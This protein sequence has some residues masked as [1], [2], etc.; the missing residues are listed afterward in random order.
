MLNEILA[1]VAGALRAA[2]G[3]GFDIYRN[4]VRQGLHEPCFFLAVLQPERT[5]LLGRRFRWTVPLDVHYFPERPGRNDELLDVA[6]RAAEA[7][8][9]ITLPDGAT[10]RGFS[11][12]CETE[13]GVLHVFVQY[14]LFLIDDA[15]KRDSMD[16]LS[17]AIG[18]KPETA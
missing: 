1:G 7:L 3:D 13:D 5:P 15:G 18:T 14:S 10:V 8:R 16:G 11:L 17:A 12:R 6:E 4:D 2:F 9:V